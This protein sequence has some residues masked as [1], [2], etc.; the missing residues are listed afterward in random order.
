MKFIEFREVIIENVKR[1]LPKEYEDWEVIEQQIP[2][3]N[4][5]ESAFFLIPKSLSGLSDITPIFYFSDLYS[6]YVSGRKIDTILRDIAKIITNDNQPE[7]FKEVDF[8]YDSVKDKII[9]QVINKDINKELLKDAVSRDC[10]DL[11][12]I[13]RI[14]LEDEEIE[15]SAIVNEQL[16][17]QWDKTEEDIYKVAYE[18]TKKL[19]PFKVKSIMAALGLKGEEKDDNLYV[20][21]NNG[22]EYGATAILYPE[23]LKEGVELLGDSFYII[24]SS[25]HEVLL[26]KVDERNTP[27]ELAKLIKAT[28]D[29]VL[30]KDDILS[31]K[32]YFYDKVN[33]E[34]TIA[35]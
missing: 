5:C 16:I 33:N 32:L 25:I 34:V 14:I 15:G 21:T 11:A 30:D 12:I 3:V 18:N 9:L 19:R 20:A 29:N 28:N 27:K 23:I 24:P 17:L 13:Y 1:Y 7:L 26:L 6:K 35:A 8:S 31:Y 2:K 22:K 10:L 4:K